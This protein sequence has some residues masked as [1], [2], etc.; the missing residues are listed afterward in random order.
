M[1]SVKSDYY[2]KAEIRN[3]R[4]DMEELEEYL[5]GWDDAIYNGNYKKKYVD[6]Y[7]IHTG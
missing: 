6:M 3:M 4:I 2:T 1:N 5:Y 7:I